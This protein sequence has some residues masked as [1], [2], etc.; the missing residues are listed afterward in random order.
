MLEE[1]E[2]MRLLR[3]WG[4]NDDAQPAYD[5]ACPKCV[6][7]GGVVA[8]TEGLIAQLDRLLSPPESASGASAHRPGGETP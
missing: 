6:G 4:D 8:R 1:V 7:P 3:L 5:H 2:A